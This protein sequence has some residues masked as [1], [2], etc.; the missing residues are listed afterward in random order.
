MTTRIIIENEYATIRSGEPKEEAWLQVEEI[1]AGLIEST[2]LGGAEA[3]LQFDHGSAAITLR[4]DDMH[5]YIGV[6]NDG[7]FVPG[8]GGVR[9]DSPP[10]QVSLLVF[11]ETDEGEDRRIDKE[12]SLSDLGQIARQAAAY[13]SW[14]VIELM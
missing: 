10:S 6:G 8:E 7:S 3:D 2:D 5:A 11:E 14:A 9:H 1:L 4:K 13:L 12:V